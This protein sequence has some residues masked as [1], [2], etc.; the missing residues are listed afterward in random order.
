MTSSRTRGC[1][2]KGL[3]GVGSGDRFTQADKTLIKVRGMGHI[4]DASTLIAASIFR[5]SS[6]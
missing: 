5:D 4:S 3:I 2:T 1:I 6:D